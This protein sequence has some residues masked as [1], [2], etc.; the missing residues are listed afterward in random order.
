MFD[1]NEFKR[2]LHAEAKRMKSDKDKSGKGEDFYKDWVQKN[3]EKFSNDWNISKCKSCFH[4][5]ECGFKTLNKCDIYTNMK[6]R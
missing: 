1:K 6:E 5:E 2:K 3:A 4:C